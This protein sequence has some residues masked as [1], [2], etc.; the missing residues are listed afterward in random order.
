VAAGVMVMMDFPEVVDI[1]G[2]ST[3]LISILVLMRQA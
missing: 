2:T 3:S 1:G